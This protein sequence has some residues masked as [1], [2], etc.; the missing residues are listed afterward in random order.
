MAG[1]IRLNHGVTTGGYGDFL[2]GFVVDDQSV[3]GRP[4]GVTAVHDGAR[5]LTED[6]HGTT[7]RAACAKG[8]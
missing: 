2:T 4:V 6:G 3:W 5:L 7:R 8:N 1:R